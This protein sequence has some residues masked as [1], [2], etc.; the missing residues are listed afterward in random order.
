MKK[1]QAMAG[2][3][4]LLG[5]AAARAELVD[6]VA[7]VVN[8]EVIAL[9]EVERRAAPEL[10]RLA[11]EPDATLRA[12]QRQKVLKNMLDML[13][14]E[15]LLQ[16][17]VKQL[18]LSA[19]EQEIQAAI[20]DV[21]QKNN[22]A[23]MQQFERLL[24]G[25]GLTLAAYKEMLGK[26]I[27]QMRLM[28]V[29]V[30][31][32][33]KVS[34]EDLKAAYVQYSRSEGEEV[35]VHARHILLQIG[36]NAPAE[37]VEAKRKRAQALAVEARKPGVD[38]AKLAREKSEGSSAEDGGD[39][40]FFGRGE[41]VPAFERVAFSL[42]VGEV[43]DPVRTNFGWHVVKVEERRAADVPPFDKVKD[44]LEGRLRQEKLLKYTDQYVQELRQKA[45]VEVKL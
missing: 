20:D 23:D 35:E 8:K 19:T 21:R 42:K 14:G 38:F 41:M 16:E 34:E 28:Q 6:R 22:I 40:G 39:L 10:Q 13:I 45:S 4:L 30:G 15:R 24:A 17:E 29:K 7:A 9:S 2:A 11:S 36:E 43:S 25:E 31:S 37:E 3:V 33:V 12:N 44:E 26:Q 1:L 32:K 5:S 18:G 27:S